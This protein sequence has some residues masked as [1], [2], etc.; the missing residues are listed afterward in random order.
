MKSIAII[1]SLL[2]LTLSA[3]AEEKSTTCT[4]GSDSRT[5][6]I[7]AAG[8]GCELTYVKKD[9][10]KVIANQKNGFSKCEEVA[11]GVQD[12]LTAAGFTCQ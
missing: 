5:L 2:F 11:K 6:D 9:S 7:K 10:S 8:T 4:S 1:A 12:K 3:Q